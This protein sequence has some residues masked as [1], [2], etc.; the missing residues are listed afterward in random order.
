MTSMMTPATGLATPTQAPTSI[1][2]A[3]TPPDNATALGGAPLS[4]AEAALDAAI[5]TACDRIAPAWPLDRAI[6]VNPCWGFIDKPF[7]EVAA[8]L[9]AFSGATMLMPRSWYRDQYRAGRFTDADL[10]AVLK[11]ANDTRPLTQLLAALARDP[12]E[13]TP[14]GFMTEAVDAGRDLTHHWSWRA[15][16]LRDISQACAACFDEGQA[17]WS[18]DRSTGLY[19]VWRTIARHDLAPR[20]LMGASHHQADMDALP[21]DPRT[22]IVEAVA[23]L[24]VAPEH[25]ADY[26]TALL[27]S[28]NGWAS[29]MAFRRWE[30]RLLGGDDE[31]LVHLLAARLAWELLLARQYATP[32]TMM[33]WRAIQHGWQTAAS[34]AAELRRDDWHFQRALELAYQRTLTRRLLPAPAADS[35]TATT[36]SAPRSTAAQ[37]V[38]C[39]D[40]RSEVMRRAVERVSPEIETLGFAGFFGVPA[41]YK[42]PEGSLRPQLPGL[43][44]PSVVIAD[45]AAGS[46]EPTDRVIARMKARAAAGVSWKQLSTTP[47]SMFTFVESAGLAWAAALLRD[48]LKRLAPTRDP[49]RADDMTPSAPQLTRSTDGTLIGDE[50]RIALAAG[51]LR[52]MSLTQDFAPLLVL[53]GH[54][55][56]TSNNPQAAALQCGA[57]G[58]QTGEL[59]ARAAAALLNDATVRVGL[60]QLGIDL[61]ETFVLAGL[62][63]TTT[64]DVTLYD[65]EHVPSAHTAALEMLRNTLR[66]AADVARAERAPGLGIT[67]AT[68]EELASRIRARARDWA[69]L[70]P[71]WG[72]AGNAAFV[73]APRARTRGLDLGGRVFLHDYRWSQ[74]NEFRVLDLLLSAPMVVAH[75]INLQYYASTVDPLRYGSGN[76]VLHN[77][78]GGRLGVLEGGQGDLRIGLARQSVHDGTA[79]RHEP[80]RLSVFVE[81]PTDAI[82]AVLARHRSVDDLVRNEW[83]HLHCLD[84]IS[85]MVTQRRA[86]GWHEVESWD[87][88]IGALHAN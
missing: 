33:V 16:V 21:D 7:P 50:Q 57:C 86:D 4:V 9:A 11:R 32:H 67:A 19:G 84:P 88:H 70:R 72:L 13:P 5:L 43:L 74:D 76:K 24:G 55:A 60:A 71:E 69:E 3:T 52:T 82:D 35:H 44:A 46:E 73:I 15:F 1:A 23:A 6:A 87:V 79:W 51:I 68:T 78:V 39:I 63:D 48:G 14:W 28:V 75:W 22:L 29:A 26:F 56:S 77:V 8:S 2:G 30:A 65:V 58:G 27:L 80:L 53:L 62:H 17:R 37:V 85:G 18:P 42:T 64:D 31:Q 83:V 45:E 36:S 38:F 41:A 40:V 59:N 10:E 66:N 81:A 20:L 34:E 54:G 25:W 61:G 47:S 12:Q 49:L